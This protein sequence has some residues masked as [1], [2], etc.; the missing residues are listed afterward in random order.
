MRR[1]PKD[2]AIIKATL[3]AF[4]VE[5]L[6]G[7]KET[8]NDELLGPSIIDVFLGVCGIDATLG[9]FQEGRHTDGFPTK[10]ERAVEVGKHFDLC[11][12]YV[13]LVLLGALG[14]LC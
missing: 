12:A 2:G 6:L 10:P 3:T 4:I 1:R 8:C 14:I 13:S 9:S 7:R 5:V 11:R